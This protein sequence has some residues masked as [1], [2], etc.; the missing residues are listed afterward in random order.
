MPQLIKAFKG[1]VIERIIAN[2]NCTFAFS[3]KEKIYCWGHMPKGLNFNRHDEVID[4]PQKNDTLQG[5]NFRDISL[6]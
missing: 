4:E 6:S 2:R 5:L 1:K 3:D